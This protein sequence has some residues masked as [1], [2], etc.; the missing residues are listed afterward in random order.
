MGPA[1]VAGMEGLG[2]VVIGPLRLWKYVENL[3]SPRATQTPGGIRRPAQSL[4]GEI[5]SFEDEL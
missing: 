1:E 5:L 2:C 3:K 4:P